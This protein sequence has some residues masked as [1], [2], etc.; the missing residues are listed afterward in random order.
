MSDSVTK[1]FE[2]LEDGTIKGTSDKRTTYIYE[3]PDGGKTVSRRPFGSN[4]DEKEVI[5]K[6]PI[7]SEGDKKQAYQILIDF[8]EKA[9]LEAARI[10][11]AQYGN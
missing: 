4:V 1:Y 9:I 8:P 5:Q 10:L 11:K 7:L 3:S 2:M 6:P